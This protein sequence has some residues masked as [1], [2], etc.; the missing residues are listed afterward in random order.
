VQIFYH[1][2]FPTLSQA[3]PCHWRSSFFGS[4]SPVEG[5]SQLEIIS[6]L[7]KFVEVY[8]LIFIRSRHKGHFYKIDC[9]NGI[10]EV[11]LLHF[12]LIFSSKGC[13]A[14][15]VSSK[16]QRIGGPICLRRSTVLS[17]QRLATISRIWQ[18]EMEAATKYFDDL[19]N[20]KGVC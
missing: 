6:C 14:S 2:G 17:A 1:V 9:F 3:F 10:A 5:P 16:A 8:F 15:T 18:T 11:C 19:N 13:A 4:V 12:T 7:R 20:V